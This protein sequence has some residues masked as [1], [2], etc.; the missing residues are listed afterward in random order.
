MIMEDSVNVSI[1]KKLFQYY[2]HSDMEG[3]M[4]LLSPE[5]IWLEPGNSEIPYS[6][7]FKG[8]EEI[9]SMIGI[10][11]KNLE[12][13]SFEATDFCEGLN[14]V[15]AIGSNEA[16][17][18]ATGKIYKTDWVYAFSLEDGKITSVQVYMDTQSIANAF[19]N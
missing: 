16:K 3:F 17:V 1:I 13:I 19:C 15:L 5:V 11:V 12:M 2:A 9:G 18:K 6:G 10:T 14:K 4:S 8:I 7:T